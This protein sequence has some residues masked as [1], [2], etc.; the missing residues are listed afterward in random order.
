MKKLAILAVMSA[1]S[2]FAFTAPAIAQPLGWYAGAGYTSYDT[3]AGDVG[4]ATGRL[5]YQFT[6]HLGVE[7][8]ASFGVDDDDGAELDNAYGIYGVG[9]LPVTERVDLFG[10]VGYQTVEVDGTAL[11]DDGDNDGLGY[12]AGVNVRLTERFGLRGEYTRLDS[13]DDVDTW[14][15]GGVVNF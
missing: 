14:G 12:G 7:G 1:V 8:E 2:A 11:A 15:I 10:R 13:D 9:T 5:G 4:A 3:E 6:P